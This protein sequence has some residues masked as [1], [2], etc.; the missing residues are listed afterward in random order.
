MA[1]E[2]RLEAGRI[3]FAK[4]ENQAQGIE[5]TLQ[6]VTDQVND[7]VNLRAREGASVAEYFA[8]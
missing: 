3:F 8:N 5:E 2:A 6:R 7:C 1:S 4:L